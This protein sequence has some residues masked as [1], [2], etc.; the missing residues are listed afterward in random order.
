MLATAHR[1]LPAIGGAYGL[2]DPPRPP[3]Q[4][5]AGLR[6]DSLPPGAEA[7]ISVAA[8]GL[9]ARPQPWQ[10]DDF[11]SDES[12]S[13]DTQDDS[14]DG[15]HRP[16]KR[17][18]AASQ[19]DEDPELAWTEEREELVASYVRRN[20]EANKKR[21]DHWE[22]MRALGELISAIGRAQDG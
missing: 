21:A 12:A 8:A 20:L 1:P 6:R 19:E 4:P 16:R 11:S 5:P 10:D 17:R 15:G 22:I 9:N 2:A 18:R 14:S 13:E 3:P 7:A